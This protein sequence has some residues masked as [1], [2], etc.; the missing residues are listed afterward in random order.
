MYI[1]SQICVSLFQWI[2]INIL[3]WK[4]IFST[5]TNSM[6]QT[7]TLCLLWYIDSFI[8]CFF[9]HINRIH[10]LQLQT[11]NVNLPNSLQ[12][13]KNIAFS[14]CQPHHVCSFV[15][16]RDK[17]RF[18]YRMNRFVSHF[19]RKKKSMTPDKCFQCIIYGIQFVLHIY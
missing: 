1:F 7:L 5:S 15:I 17:I 2:R 3:E 4:P 13:N 6:H 14:L 10:R 12:T 16:F 11:E 9:G 18:Q 19:V 8:K